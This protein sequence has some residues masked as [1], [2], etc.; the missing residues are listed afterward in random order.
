M[1][2]THVLNRGWPAVRSPA[3]RVL[4]PPTLAGLAKMGPR[5]IDCAGPQPIPGPV[6]HADR[7][8]GLPW[9]G[10]SGPPLPVR[11]A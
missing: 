11:G 2:Y 5:A 3:D 4:T 10:D 6:A 7:R 8:E 1:I 9:P